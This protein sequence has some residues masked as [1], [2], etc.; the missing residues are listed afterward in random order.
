MFFKVEFSSATFSLN[1]LFSKF[2]HKK[3]ICYSVHFKMYKIT[4]NFFMIKFREEF[5]EIKSCG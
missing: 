1:K 2:Y 5:T 3:V 4:N